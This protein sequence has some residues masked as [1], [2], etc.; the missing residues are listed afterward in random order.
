MAGM[1]GLGRVF[2]LLGTASGVGI[3]MAEASSITFYG[4]ND[5]TYTLTCSKTFAGSY[6]TPAGWAPI[7]TAYTN[8][9]NGVGTGGWTKVTQAASTAVTTATDIAVAFTVMTSGLPDGYQ[10]VKCTKTTDNDGNP[11]VMAIVHDLTVQRTP[12]NLITLSA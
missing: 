5:G 10:Y 12:A 9:D 3:N 4:T 8:A 2:N 7:A 6:T 11:S 1:Q